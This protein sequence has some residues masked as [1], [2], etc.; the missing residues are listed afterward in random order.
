[1]MNADK[2]LEPPLETED[3]EFHSF[4]EEFEHK[5]FEG[6]EQVTA[7]VTLMH[8]TWESI[9]KEFEDNGW[10]QNEG[11]IVLLT[12]G[13][14]FLRAERAL[15]I[16]ESA[17]G[18]RDAEVDKLIKRLIEIESRLA[19]MKNFAYDMMRDHRV[20]ELQHEAIKLE[21]NG[22][23]RLAAR[24]KEENLAF[25]AENEQLKY[26]LKKYQSA[27]DMSVAEPVPDTRSRWRRAFDILVG[28]PDHA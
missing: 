3:Q 8:D 14:A 2:N 19:A 18:M 17:A 1:M 22:Y 12:T 15:T 7:Q 23:H 10:K 21:A 5:F 16:P 26:E 24:L 13:L 25:R 4:T 11:L 27:T 28:K 6:A 9:L 20:M